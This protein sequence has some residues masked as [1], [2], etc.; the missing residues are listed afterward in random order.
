MKPVSIPLLTALLLSAQALAPTPAPAE[1]SDGEFVIS[2]GRKGG[3]YYRVAGRL[4][5]QLTVEHGVFVDLVTSEGSIDNLER[6]QDPLSKVNIGLTQ[7]D[8]LGRYLDENPDFAQAFMVL[9]DVGKECVFLVA[10]EKGDVRHA[11]DLKKEG[12][13]LSVDS[14]SSGTA[15]TWASMG[16][17]EPA[18]RNTRTAHVEVMEGLLQLQNGPPISELDVVMLVQRPKTVSPPL[19]IVLRSPDKFRIAPVRA[20]DITSPTLPNGDPVYTH[21]TVK[22][23]FAGNA[24]SFETIC[25][26]GLLVAARSKLSEEARSRLVEVLLKSKDYIAPEE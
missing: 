13:L 2:A 22:T 3:N 5:N 6:L 21:E 8:A 19:E 15:I 4:R 12:G 18:F 14:P 25:T 23:R 7:T 17:I 11:G 24:V 16:H 20:E 26:R 10:S 1:V 9:A